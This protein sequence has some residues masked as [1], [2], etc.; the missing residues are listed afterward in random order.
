MVT[1]FPIMCHFFLSFLGFYFPYVCFG[2][3][4]K[5]SNLIY[6][7]FLSF[8]NLHFGLST[9][10]AYFWS[11]FPQV[12]LLSPSL[13]LCLLKSCYKDMRLLDPHFMALWLYLFL[14][15]CFLVTDYSV[16]S[17]LLLSSSSDVIADILSLQFLEFPSGCIFLSVSYLSLLWFLMAYSSGTCFKY[18]KC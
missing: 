18:L 2:S 8:F 4:L 1:S 5:V 6:R 16:I 13:S 15:S 12:V 14:K 10:L 7:D 3:N 17:N 9:G 11:L